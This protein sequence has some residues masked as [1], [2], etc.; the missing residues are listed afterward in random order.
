MIGD[1]PIVQ[2]QNDRLGGQNF[3]NG[4]LPHFGGESK[5][6][7]D[8]ELIANNQAERLD[9]DESCIN[10]VAN[11]VE[12][13]SIEQ[14]PGDMAA[15]EGN[16]LTLRPAAVAGTSKLET[17]DELQQARIRA[18]NAVLEAEKFHTQVEQAV[19]NSMNAIFNIGSRVSDDNFFHL[20][21]HTKPNLLHKIEKGKFIELEKLLPK[22]K[23]GKGR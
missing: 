2:W 22:D 16:T 13:V 4:N 1:Q 9:V 14:H 21:C 18:D 19:N 7:I 6:V 17:D 3:D 23:L 11:F 5:R 10:Q 12:A 8:T 15:K 20:T